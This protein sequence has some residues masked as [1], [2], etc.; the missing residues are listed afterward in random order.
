MANAD[1]RAAKTN[2]ALQS[3]ERSL[4]R[5]EKAFAGRKTELALA[6]D[7][8]AARSDYEKLAGTARGVD[9]RLAGVRERLQ[10]VLGS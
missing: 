8:A 9:A 7:V 5:L 4:T 1:S 3:L 10:A 6:A 2:T